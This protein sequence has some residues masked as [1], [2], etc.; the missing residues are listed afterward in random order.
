MPPDLSKSAL[1]VPDQDDCV[2]E[3]ISYSDNVHIKVT[4]KKEK[5][6]DRIVKEIET[7][8][9]TLTN[10]KSIGKKIVNLSKEK[11]NDISFVELEKNND[12]DE[13]GVQMKLDI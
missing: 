1:V 6:K 4:Y 3:N 9:I 8:D 10:Y 5:G 11:I 12:L 7:N 2:L 13:S